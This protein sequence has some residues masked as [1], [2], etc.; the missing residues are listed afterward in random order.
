MNKNRK[1]SHIINILQYDE[2]TGAVTMSGSMTAGSLIKSGGTSSQF[3][4]AD[5]SV[6]SNVYATSSSVTSSLTGYVT[7]TTMQ[8]ITGIKTF[9]NETLFGNGITLTGGYITYTSG[10]YN[11][12]LNTNILTANRNVFLKDGSGTLAFTSDIPSLSGYIQ[13]SGTTNYM[14]KFTASGSIG[15]SLVYD[16]GSGVGVNTSSPYD[17]S[18]FKLDVNGGVIIKNTTG[19]TAQLILIDSNPATGGNNG[20]VQL[21]TGGNTGT[22]YAQWQTFYGT[23]IASGTFRMQ[24]SGGVVLIG[25]STAVTGAGVLQVAGDVNITGAFKVNGAAIISGVSSFNT[26]TGSITLSSADITGALGYTPYNSTNPSG[27]TTN[28][29]TVTSVSGAGTVSGLT[30]TGTVTTSGS[31]TLGGTLTLTSS[32]ITTGLGYTPYN[33]TNP[34]GYITSSSNISG[35]AMSLN[36]YAN[37]TLYT[38]LDGPANGPVIKVRYDSATANRYIDFGSK[39][40]NGVYTEGF[41]IYNGG[42]PT[43][44]GNTIWHG[45]NLTNLNQLTNGPGYITGITSGNVTT[46]LGY[47]PYNSTNPSGYITSSASITG[48]SAGVSLTLSGGNDANLVYA[49]IADNDFFRIRVGGT[50]NAGWAEIA[51]AD[52]GTEPIYVRQYTGVFSSLTRTATLLDGSGNT[53]FPGTVTASSFSGSIAW[54]NVSGRPTALSSFTN[55]LGNYGGWITASGNTSGYAGYLPTS[56]AGGVQSNPQT[57]FGQSVGVKV[58]MTG[59]WSTWSDTLWINGYAGGDVL[60]MCALHTLRNGTPRMAISVQASNSS[61]Y[62]TYYE[63]ITA[64]NI[65]SQSVSYASNSGALNGWGYG[66]YAYRASGSG[67]Y[68]IDTWLQANGNFGIYWPSYYGLHLYPNNDGSYGSLQVKGNKNSWHGIH[69]DSGTALMMNSN[70]SGH[71]REGYGWQYRWSNGSFYISSNA[72]GGGSEYTA[73]HS[74]NIGSQTVSRADGALKLWATSHPY[75]Y[76]IVNNWTGAHWQLTTNHGSP[77]RVG[78]ADSAGSAGSASTA[79]NVYNINYALGNSH[80]WTGIQYFQTNNG[81]SAV[82]NSNTAALEA[83]S[84][85]NNTAFMSFHKGGYYAINM[86]L[87]GDNVFRIGGW[88]AGGNRLQMDMSGNL[89][90]AGDVTAYSDAR[91]KENIITVDNALSKVLALRGVYYNRIDSED[92]SRK[93]GV[94][95]QE[96]LTVVPEVVNTDTSGT[97]NVS[98]GNLGGLFIEAFKEQDTIIKDQAEVI[99]GLQEQI[100]VLKFLVDGLTK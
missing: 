34:N 59:S 57:Y 91:V 6:D 19:T 36:G 78:Y 3:L 20:F 29:G 40:G 74:G 84:T 37:Q 64:Y 69:F 66:S 7:L 52:D 2:T 99:K 100:D 30:L 79:T 14:A 58:A 76:Y 72:Y 10:S 5:G 61:S 85:G 70:E 45:G 22:A 92:K 26:R 38:I 21:T 67:Y 63:F 32:Q 68:Q 80:Y 96:M 42:T 86:G 25:S 44:A 94:I 87:D 65:A 60:Q 28:V 75:D 16:N 9:G 49:A 13:G 93:I 82:N 43:W 95:A 39:D 17:S 90:M 8:T 88:S 12:T 71:H 73:I 35:Y 81:G 27:Y 54:S 11:L 62:G 1:I 33:S 41:K 47:T 31:L 23:S 98:Y 55:D 77:V 46:A 89:T 83:Y 18:Q 56:Y 24:P 97:Y 50:S 51:T 4:K 15:N 53:S 48:T